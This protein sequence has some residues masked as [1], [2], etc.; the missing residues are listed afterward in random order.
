MYQPI[1]ERVADGIPLNIFHLGTNK[2]GSTYLQ[3]IIVENRELIRNAGLLYPGC[4]DEIGYGHHSIVFEMQAGNRR[5]RLR[6]YLKEIEKGKAY[7][8]LSS[9]GMAEL[10]Q[11]AL[12][13]LAGVSKRP[14]FAVIYFREPTGYLKSAFQE[15]VRHGWGGALENPDPAGITL[16]TAATDPNS[17]VS[18]NLVA[19]ADK[20]TRAFGEERTIFVAF[21]N[22][23]SAGK[24]LFVHFF[25]DVLGLSASG[26]DCTKAYRNEHSGLQIQE[27]TRLINSL[28]ARRN[29]MPG[30]WVARYVEYLG[31][32]LLERI[33]HLDRLQD[34][35]RSCAMHSRAGYYKDMERELANRFGHLFANA[36]G[37]GWIFNHAYEATLESYDLYSFL[38]S[39][40]TIVLAIDDLAVEFIN[41]RSNNPG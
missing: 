7:G 6:Q 18:M 29:S 32:S 11:E 9:E 21:D 36:S 33:P 17:F 39:D 26:I 37:N 3:S 41:W 31:T 19:L 5:D 27:V 35:K 28:I 23:K 25:E 12:G 1:S 38:Q 10:D 16:N 14:T 20:V 24:D 15:G 40:P 8:L 2:T 13:E 34:F 22:V 30:D 4:N